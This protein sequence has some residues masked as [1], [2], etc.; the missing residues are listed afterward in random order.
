LL[1]M[2]EMQIARY[3]FLN[4]SYNIPGSV[5]KVFAMFSL[6]YIGLFFP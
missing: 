3:K 5:N 6:R 1:K 2:S 4:F